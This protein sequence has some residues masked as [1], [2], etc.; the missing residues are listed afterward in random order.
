VLACVHL[1]IKL[2]SKAPKAVGNVRHKGWERQ[3]LQ[4]PLQPSARRSSHHS[5]A[6]PAEALQSRL[7]HCR[8]RLSSAG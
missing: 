6:E 4:A 5:T 8:A 1:A 2:Q 3:A 7:I